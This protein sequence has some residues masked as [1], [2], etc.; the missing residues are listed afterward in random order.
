MGS[1]FPFGVILAQEPPPDSALG[2]DAKVR[3]TISGKPRS[4][5]SE[6][7]AK[8]FHYAVPQGSSDS[9]VRI[10]LEDAA[11][12]R[13]L[14]AGLRAPGSKVDVALPASAKQARIKV[15]LNGILVEEQDL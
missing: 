5:A 4:A 15:Y 13:E 11:G 14:F 6:S 7:S 10:L 3:L 1:L 12:E 9:Q 8:M 2:A